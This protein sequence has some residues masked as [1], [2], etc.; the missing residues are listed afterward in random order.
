MGKIVTL[1]SARE[2]KSLGSGNA[3]HNLTSTHA[4]RPVATHFLP[5]QERCTML[6]KVLRQEGAQTGL[7]FC[8]SLV[9]STQ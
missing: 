6:L 7:G 2:S 9:G 4:Q 8:P 3:H 5:A 1:L